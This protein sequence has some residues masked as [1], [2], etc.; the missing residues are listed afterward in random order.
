MEQTFVMVK[1][2]GVKRGLV[3]EIVQRFERMG[4][5]IVAMKMV[6]EA[7]RFFRIR[8]THNRWKKRGENHDLSND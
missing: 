1:P 4:L 7:G 2:D 6:L 3:G 5:K 8:H